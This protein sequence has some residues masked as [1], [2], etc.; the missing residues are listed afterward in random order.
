MSR[1][2]CASTRRCGICWIAITA[3][4]HRR[5]RKR[6]LPT[7]SSA[8]SSGRS[9]AATR[10]LE[11]AAG[12]GRRT[13]RCPQLLRSPSSCRLRP[14]CAW[15]CGPLRCMASTAIMFILCRDS[16]CILAACLVRFRE[17]SVI[18]RPAAPVAASAAGFGA[19]I[20]HRNH[21]LS[22]RR[23]NQHGDGA[24]GRNDR[25]L[26]LERKLSAQSRQLV[27]DPATHHPPDRDLAERAVVGRTADAACRRTRRFA[28]SFTT[29][30]FAG[31]A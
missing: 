22:G 28:R 26:C 25:H 12:A 24:E 7:S 19:A 23:R 30:G 18:D 27:R 10:M 20:L 9:A 6:S 3:W 4:S 15:C 21:R 11:P 1:A 8:L 14:R 17:W 29:A 16:A 5:R 13:A 2:R 31:K